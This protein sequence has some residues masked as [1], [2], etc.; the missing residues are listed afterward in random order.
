MPYIDPTGKQKGYSSFPQTELNLVQWVDVA[1]EPA[2]IVP[3]AVSRFQGREAMWQTPHGEV[4]LF[5]AAEV[6]LADPAT[7]AMYRR[8]WDDLQEFR[9]DS[10]MLAAVAGMLGLTAAQIDALFI[11]AAGIHA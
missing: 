3:Q 11:L 5:E 10:E 9:R 6:V 1:P 4:S 2:P 7:P 8:A